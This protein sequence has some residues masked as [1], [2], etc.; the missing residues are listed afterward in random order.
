ML[1]TQ[2][3][4]QYKKQ[5]D[6]LRS[7][8]EKYEQMN[9][10]Q[11]QQSRQSEMVDSEVNSQQ[12]KRVSQQPN[13]M[14]HVRQQQQHEDA[15]AHH[16]KDQMVSAFPLQ[17]NPPNNV[18]S[19]GFDYQSPPLYGSQAVKAPSPTPPKHSPRQEV[20]EDDDLPPPIMLSSQ[21]S[22]QSRSP[23]KVWAA[24]NHPHNAPY[25]Q[26]Y[27]SHSQLPARYAQTDV[28]ASH[29][30]PQSNDHSHYQREWRQ[31]ADMQVSANSQPYLGTSVPQPRQPVQEPNPADQSIDLA[32]GIDAD[33]INVVDQLQAE[34]KASNESADAPL[35]PNLT[36]P[37]CRTVFRKGEIQ[38]FR[39]HVKLCDK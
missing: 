28:G 25:Q 13:P 30:G 34:G 29:Y 15:H 14:H 11:A 3:V 35:D 7:Q 36:C 17:A 33:I 32:K 23:V 5:A 18:Y 39:R 6:N 12:I 27:Q 8:V 16:M 21:P 4:K 24:S 1:L 2:Q 31:T 20:P 22:T 10:S 37:V 9:M 26:P 38:A 19:Q